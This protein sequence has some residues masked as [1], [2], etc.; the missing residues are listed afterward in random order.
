MIRIEGYRGVVGDVKALLATVPKGVQLL[1][2][3]RVFG[4]EHVEHA[5]KL[6]ERA[7]GEGRAR[8]AD[9]QTEL[10]LYAAGLRQVGK[11][12]S[13]LGL[14]P[15][16]SSVVVVSWGP[17]WS[18]PSAW[19]RDDAVIE[20]DVGVLDAFGVS[21]VERAMLPPERWGDFILERVALLDVAK[22]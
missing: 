16:V 1:R 9:V 18:P 7:V 5:A 10:V 20:G 3:D 21:A 6:A 13:F 17:H 11:A 14:E 15:G 19:V 4:R 8:A 12:L 2:A 22:S